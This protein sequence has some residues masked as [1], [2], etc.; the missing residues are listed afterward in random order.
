M[1]PG[2]FVAGFLLD[3]FTLQRIDLLYENLVL[4][5]HLFISGLAIFLLNAREKGVFQKIVTQKV[6]RFLPILMQFSFGA[7]FSAFFIFYSR[8]ASFAA[9]WPFILFL[10]FSMFANEIFSKGYKR[11]IFQLAIYFIILFSY[12]IFAV[13]VAIGKIGAAVFVACG[14]VSLVLLAFFVYFLSFVIKEK[15][16]NY[17]RLL[18]F[19]ILSIY[20]V[21]N[22]LYFANIIPPIPLALKESGIYHKVERINSDKYN[23]S[24]EPAPWYLLFRD[25]DPTFHRLPGEAVYSYSAVFAPTKIDTKIYHRWSYF[26]EQKN[27]W[28]VTDRLGFSIVG[29]RDGGYRGYT[30]KRNIIHGEWKVEVITGRNQILGYTKF[31]VKEVDFIPQLKTTTR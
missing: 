7:L 4:V 16:I 24:F 29:G 12:S 15:L 2:A 3:S 17:R 20:F 21:F 5:I 30:M 28:V 11:L 27:E 31:K 19:V 25:F 18:N 6:V 13:P 1:M 22:V 14:I 26:D 8:S 9:S 10:V 23:I